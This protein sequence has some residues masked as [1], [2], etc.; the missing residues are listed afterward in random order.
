MLHNSRLEKR[1]RKMQNKHK[2]KV[3]INNFQR[4]NIEYIHDAQNIQIS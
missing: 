1:K 3:V 4:W 2:P